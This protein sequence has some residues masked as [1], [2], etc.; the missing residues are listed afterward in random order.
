MAERI[1]ITIP[2]TLRARLQAVRKNLNIS[3]VCQEAIEGVVNIEELKIA[4]KG[5]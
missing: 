4:G 5:V 3:A 2:D 1:T